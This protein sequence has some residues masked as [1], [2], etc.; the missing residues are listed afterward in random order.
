MYGASFIQA[1]R[2]PVMLI[3]LGVLLAIHQNTAWGFE[4]TFPVL[5]IVFGILKLLER[6]AEKSPDQQSPQ[7]PQTGGQ[8]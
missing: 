8:A 4:Q 3:T 6:S 7:F 5:I 1:A 2:G